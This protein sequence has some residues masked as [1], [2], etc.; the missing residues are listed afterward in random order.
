LPA[1]TIEIGDAEK[2]FSAPRASAARTR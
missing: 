2:G 1:A